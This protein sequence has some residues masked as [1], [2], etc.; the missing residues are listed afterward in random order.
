MENNN[1]QFFKDAIMS[2]TSMQNSFFAITKYD[3]FLFL[4]NG[5]VRFM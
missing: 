3:L 5:N 4:L 2:L 1:E